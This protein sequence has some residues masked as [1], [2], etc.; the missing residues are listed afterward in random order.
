MTL[1]IYQHRTPLTR[2]FE[3]LAA[4]ELTIGLLGGSI[5]A[6][7]PHN[8][9]EPVIA[10]L[11]NEYPD[12]ALQVE[13]AA[14]GSTTSESALFRAEQDIIGRDC[15]LLF[16]EYAVNDHQEPPEKR[17]RTREGLLRKLLERTE[18]DLVLVY[19]FRQEMYEDMMS[20]RMPSSI[21]GLEQLGEHYQL[22]SVW[23]GLYA[24]QEVVHGRLRWEAWLPDGLHPQ[25]RGSQCYADSVIAFLETERRQVG[26][27]AAI[28]TAPIPERLRQPLPE[29]LDP[30]HWQASE[31]L[32]LRG[33]ERKGPWSLRRRRDLASLG[34]AL[35]TSAPD[36]ALRFGFEG[37]GL[38]LA[39]LFG[40]YTA[41]FSYRIDGGEWQASSL[42]RSGWCPEKGYPKM[43][44]ISDEL[45][46]GPHQVELVTR[47]GGGLHCK[48]TNFELLF[49]GVLK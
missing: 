15:D 45:G 49:A 46:P 33:I 5:T 21:A 22:G 27:Q 12:A 26:K 43:F 9:S 13:N 23:M 20:G 6:P 16:V 2:T 32:D 14:I 38:T 39:F 29:P 47:H 40:K 3:K 10:W 48:G 1:S 37:R 41:E 25:D 7:A 28:Q 34:Q 44:T 11:A 24:L 8:W 31:L 18:A 19:T 36:A 42:D 35:Y 4:G 17:M 30:G